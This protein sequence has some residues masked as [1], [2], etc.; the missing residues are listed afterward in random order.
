MYII[1]FIFAY[2]F[3]CLFI[4][5]FY[6]MHN[7]FIIELYLYLIYNAFFLRE[8]FFFREFLDYLF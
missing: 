6:N 4:V 8:C 2:I 7:Y 1:V 3:L 5:A